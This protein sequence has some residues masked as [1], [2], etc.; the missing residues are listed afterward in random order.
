MSAF[1]IKICFKKAKTGRFCAWRAWND[2]NDHS[3]VPGGKTSHFCYNQLERQ[4]LNKDKE[5]N[6]H[7]K[8]KN[9]NFM[10]VPKKGKKMVIMKK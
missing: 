4:M 2:P 7:K 10:N 5:M 6:V 8:A 9:S 3:E 1:F